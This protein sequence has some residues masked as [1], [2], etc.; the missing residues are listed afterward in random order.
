M[1]LNVLDPS[2]FKRISEY[3]DVANVS[4]DLAITEAVNEFMDTTGDLLLAEMKRNRPRR[5]KPVRILTT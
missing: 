4:I 5:K 3:A 1:P 2:T